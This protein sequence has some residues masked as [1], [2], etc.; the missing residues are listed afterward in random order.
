MNVK[1]IAIISLLRVQKK[2]ITF[3]SDE[4]VIH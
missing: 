1:K 3:I 4:T 2:K